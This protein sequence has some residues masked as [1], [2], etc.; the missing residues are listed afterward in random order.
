MGKGGKVP[1]WQPMSPSP[2]AWPVSKRCLC[3]EPQGL[4]WLRKQHTHMAVRVQ[5]GHWRKFRRKNHKQNIKQ[6]NGI[7]S[8]RQRACLSCPGARNYSMKQQ[9]PKRKWGNSTSPSYT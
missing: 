8:A 9:K 2:Q 3:W 1:K 7:S 5:R 6:L 4:R